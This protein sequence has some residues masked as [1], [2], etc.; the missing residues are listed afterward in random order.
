MDFLNMDPVEIGGIEWVVGRTPS[1]NILE[2]GTGYGVSSRRLAAFENASVVT[3][4]L[5]DDHVSTGPLP[6]NVEFIRG[7]YLSAD[8]RSQVESKGPYDAIIMDAGGT[9]WDLKR[10]WYMYRP[11]LANGG[12]FLVHDIADGEG[13]RFWSSSEDTMASLTYSIGPNLG[14]VVPDVYSQPSIADTEK[15]LGPRGVYRLPISLDV[16]FQVYT[17]PQPH[18]S[19]Q[20]QLR[21]LG[22]SYTDNPDQAEIVLLFIQAGPGNQG[23]SYIHDGG[24][25]WI[26]DL[27]EEYLDRIIPQKRL[28]CRMEGV[29]GAS[30]LANPPL[31]GPTYVTYS[32]DAHAA[33][34]QQGRDAHLVPNGVDTDIMRDVP[35]PRA[36]DFVSFGHS[37]YDDLLYGSIPFFSSGG[38]R[39]LHV[40]GDRF[41][42]TKYV[43][44]AATD[45]TFL[46]P[47]TSMPYIYNWSRY[48][49]GMLVGHGFE[50]S[51]IE[52]PLCGCMP[53][54]L[55]MP[56]YRHWFAGISEFVDRWPTSVDD[57]EGLEFMQERLQDIVTQ[58][59]E[60]TEE[61]KC[62]IR[63][64]F[65]FAAVRRQITE[66]I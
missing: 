12:A 9:L 29:S 26:S 34:L 49:N 28:I 16:D 4:D 35:I 61:T 62:R 21:G 59:H 50:T 47:H 66:L 43:G 24:T 64:E 19:M 30:I 44:T 31:E 27:D 25:T 40:G 15:A 51:N 36:Y 14:V 63:D 2:I 65:G 32:P 18:V 52:A 53:I 57:A 23:Y 20:A 56:N 5:L 54:C 41:A 7:C 42:A 1:P 17:P 8:T 45:H 55:D 10:A 3:V 60:V 13:R 6:R 37:W 38:R 58:G 33:M 39:S 48:A 22:Y 46:V 11:L